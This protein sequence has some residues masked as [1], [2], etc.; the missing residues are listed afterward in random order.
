MSISCFIQIIGV[1]KYISYI[2]FRIT[3]PTLIYRRYYQH[4]S[5]IITPGGCKWQYQN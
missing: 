2:N 5:S 3:A 4:I 1:I